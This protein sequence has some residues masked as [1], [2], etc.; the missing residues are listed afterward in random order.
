MEKMW[1]LKT[2]PVPIIM[3]AIGMIKKGTDKHINKISDS[4]S[5]IYQ[6]FYFAELLIS[7]EYYQCDG[8][9][10]P[11]KAAKSIDTQNVYNHYPLRL[12]LG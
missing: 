11:K 7:L 9:I 5:L 2:T 10:S 4:P 12:G 8:K 1:L 3:G 6:K